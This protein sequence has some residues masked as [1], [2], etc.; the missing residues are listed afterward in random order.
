M[1][2][3][4]QREA[5]LVEMGGG[6]ALDHRMY[7]GKKRSNA[8]IKQLA[9]R[10]PDIGKIKQKYMTLIH[11]AHGGKPAAACEVCDGAAVQKCGKCKSAWYC[12]VDC[13]TIHWKSTH[14]LLCG[15]SPIVEPESLDLPWEF[16]W[17]MPDD[18]NF[19]WRAYDPSTDGVLTIGRCRILACRAVRT[20]WHGFVSALH[21]EQ[22]GRLSHDE[23]ELVKRWIFLDWDTGFNH[24][25]DCF[26]GFAVYMF[27]RIFGAK[28]NLAS[29]SDFPSPY[30]PADKEAAAVRVPLELC[31]IA[32]RAMLDFVLNI[33]VPPMTVMHACR[34]TDFI[35]YDG[36]PDGKRDHWA[37]HKVAVLSLS[38]RMSTLGC[39]WYEAV[40]PCRHTL[41]IFGSTQ[42]HESSRAFGIK[43]LVA[44]IKLRSLAYEILGVTPD[45]DLFRRL[46]KTNPLLIRALGASQADGPPCLDVGDVQII[47][48]KL[49]KHALDAVLSALPLRSSLADADRLDCCSETLGT[50]SGWDMRAKDF[51]SM[52]GGVEAASK[53]PV[54]DL[55]SS[56]PAQ[57]RPF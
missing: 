38:R 46:S 15:K 19:A 55:F 28:L 26:Y 49:R 30:A 12:S 34:D 8:A 54:F 48:G 27:H 52:K 57:M 13:Q 42:T 11:S 18:L 44:F 35:S 32:Q 17:K 9:E 22:P 24:F 47:R 25:D 20:A 41:S 7:L 29:M 39:C 5:V 53:D 40:V 2:R 3:R 45:Q 6:G 33:L 43:W 37:T 31:P 56:V 36:S 21:S 23:W 14:K 50:L 4:L 1:A 16:F 10:G 51:E